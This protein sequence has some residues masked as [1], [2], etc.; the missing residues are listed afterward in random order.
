[1]HREGKE[2]RKMERDWAE[3]IFRALIE[4]DGTDDQRL[5]EAQLI[6]AQ[7]PEMQ[8]DAVNKALVRKLSANRLWRLTTGD[9]EAFPYVPLEKDM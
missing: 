4:P 9:T 5:T 1:M 2:V 8:R 6:A 7:V 3:E